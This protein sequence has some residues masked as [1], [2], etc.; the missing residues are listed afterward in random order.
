MKNIYRL[1]LAF[2]VFAALTCPIM[3]GCASTERAPERAESGV[4]APLPLDRQ[5]I[6]LVCPINTVVPDEEIAYI[7]HALAPL[8]RRDLFCVR[9]LGVIPTEDV[10]VPGSA[11]FLSAAGL[12]KLA[13][14]HGADMVTVGLLRGDKSDISIDFRVY[15]ATKG[16]FLLSTKI[17][18][19][20]SHVLKMQRDIVYQ[21]IEATGIRLSDE[22]ED[23]IKFCTPKKPSAITLFGRG[24]QEE[25][26]GRYTEALVT[27]G[28]ALDGDKRLAVPYAAEARVFKEYGAPLRSVTSLE[29]ALGRDKYYAEAWYELN[30]YVSKYKG[31]NETAIKCCEQAIEI[32][33]RFGKARLSLGVRLYNRG[34]TAGAIEETRKA[35]D[36]LPGDPLPRYN[37]GFYYI[38]AGKPDEARPWLEQALKIDPGFKPAQ[39]ELQRLL[40]K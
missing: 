39:E 34:D 19:K 9:Q 29:M 21:F 26:T 38:E 18:G 12:E 13:Q 1:T 40:G 24:L 14:A 31:D 27:L 2:F 23:K 28:D 4:T 5:P 22:D 8:I 36:L 35:V 10:Q 20:R 3:Q 33:P 30:M 11:F 17:E 37:I 6:V 32:A 16:F 25:K 15:D 7:S